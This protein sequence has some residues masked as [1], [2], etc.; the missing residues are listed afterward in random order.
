MSTKGKILIVEDEAIIALSLSQ[1]LRK[2]GYEV[3][4]HFSE[5]ESAIEYLSKHKSGIDELPDLILMD[6]MLLGKMDGTETAEV[7]KNKFKIPV[8]FL[9]ALSGEMI[10][11]KAKVTEPY[12]YII[13]PFNERELQMSIEIALYKF[14]AEL[15]IQQSEAKFRAIFNSINSVFYSTDMDGTIEM[16]SP[17]VE[18]FSGYTPES[19]LGKKTSDFYFD[20]NDRERLMA[21]LTTKGYANEFETRVKHLNG[22][23]IDVSADIKYLENEEGEITGICGNIKDITHIKKTEQQAYNYLKAIEQSHEIIYIT[24]SSG[25]IQFANNK[26]AE[27]S[28]Y[29]VHELLGQSPRLL[30]SG[31]IHR[32]FFKKMWEDLQNGRVVE[33]TFPN[34][35][36][37]G[38]IY[39]Q[40][41]IISP[42]RNKA[43]KISLFVCTGKDITDK[44]KARRKIELLNHNQKVRETESNKN[45]ISSFI[46]GQE[47]E[48]R[49]VSNEIHDGLCQMLSMA[50]TSLINGKD[51]NKSTNKSNFDELLDASI[52]EAK[53]ISNNLSPAVLTDFGLTAGLKKL[54]HVN[55]AN[56]AKTIHTRIAGSILRLSSQQ[57]LALFRIAQEAISNSIKHS[58]CSAIYVR[59][60]I[61]DKHL[62]LNLL[63]NGKGFTLDRTRI[64]SSG[65]GLGN[66][67]QRAGLIGAE[68]NIK[69]KPGKYSSIHVKIKTNTP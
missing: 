62:I 24:D 8:V 19:M 47:E 1:A 2:I 4:T 65:L 14:K 15:K 9:T 39:Y 51:R 11:E 35:K 68:L 46:Q 53:R 26:T 5:G 66:I 61:H 58:N 59:L 7:I 44:I 13:K 34:R 21:I 28:G 18:K 57:E 45:I 32:S 41:T 12:A 20:E 23:I 60:Y 3:L 16:I 63:D 55:N 33:T 43:G 22:S 67:K 27:V 6:I 48:R 38:R 64:N 49:R 10:F 29:S 25:I 40:E 17:S 50:K 56:T 30:R 37:N 52:I 54:I 42:I 36:K 69:S 31:L